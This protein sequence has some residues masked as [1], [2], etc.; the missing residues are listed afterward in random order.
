M[1]FWTHDQ[2]GAEFSAS[3]THLQ[4]YKRFPPGGEKARRTGQAH[5]HLLWARL[6]QRLRR[7]VRQAKRLRRRSPKGHQRSLRDVA[8][9]LAKLGFVNERGTAFSPSSINSKDHP[10]EDCRHQRLLSR[11]VKNVG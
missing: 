10:L 3:T 2:R 6:H 9:E 11:K 8:A 1:V 7:M 4:H 5:G